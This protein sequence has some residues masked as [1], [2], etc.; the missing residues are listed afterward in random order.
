MWNLYLGFFFVLSFTR[1]GVGEAGRI[2]DIFQTPN[3]QTALHRIG[4]SK[5]NR[6]PHLKRD[7]FQK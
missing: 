4:K 2:L 5:T 3:L 7:L 6:E 1:C